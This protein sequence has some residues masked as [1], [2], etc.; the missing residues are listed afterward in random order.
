MTDGRRAASWQAAL[1]TLMIA[2]SVAAPG[3]AQAAGPT[4]EQQSRALFEKGSK[5]M[6][7][8]DFAQACRLF[9]AAHDL[10]S[11][12]GTALRTADCYEKIGK[13]ELALELYK[14]IVAH[15][16]TEKEPARLALAETRVAA[17]KKQLGIDQPK[18]PPGQQTTQTVIVQ[19]QQPPPPPPPPPPNRVP[20]FVAFGVAGLG[21]VAGGVLGGV[22]LVEANGLKSLCPNPANCEGNM[23]AENKR[24]LTTGLAWGS[25]GGLILGAAGAITGVVL[26]VTARSPAARK[27]A[28]HALG[29]GGLT[30]RF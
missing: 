10:N 9:Q 4:T 26:L 22:A 2:A 5:A 27:A 13:S 15:R 6:E 11:T 16:D 17:L 1:A 25:N 20:A 24:N 28:Q 30:L 7:D 8:G 21:F 14:W 29:P 19:L 12:G 23:P 18:P 3:A